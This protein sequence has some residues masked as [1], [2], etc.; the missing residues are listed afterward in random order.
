MPYTIKT[1]F[2]FAGQE[3]GWSESFYW[4]KAT[5]NLTE[6]ETLVTPLAQKRAALL[7]DTYTLTIGRNAIVS[8]LAGEK[9]K[10]VVDVFEPRYPGTAAW[11]PAAPNYSLMCRWQN[12][13]NTANKPQYM[14]GIPAGL[15]DLGKLPN[16]G[17][18]TWLSLFN[19]WRS[20]MIAFNAG[21]RVT[22]VTQ[23]AQITNYVMNA[24]TGIVTFTL[25]APGVT[26]PVDPG[27]QT[28]VWVKLPNRN[29]MD[30]S[31]L[32]VPVSDTTC[33][34]VRPYGV[35]P[36]PTAQIGIMEVRTPSLVTLGPEPGGTVTGQIH[37]QRILTHKTGTPSYASR[38]RSATKVHW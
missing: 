34:T 37:P 26:W 4:T 33:Y 32:V 9:V 12:A 1:T 14:R 7:A 11:K 15:G 13:S 2:Y 10:R 36:F 17:F 24:T 21:W 35:Q 23:A 29:P 31:L 38:G 18:G 3:Q 20:A 30:G 27:Y 28:T 16:V 5:N 19:S 8:G 25:G 22:A 6:A